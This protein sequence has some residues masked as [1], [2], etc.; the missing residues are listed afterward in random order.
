ML[1]YDLSSGNTVRSSSSYVC[2][3]ESQGCSGLLWVALGCSGLLYYCRLLCVQLFGKIRSA[4]W[5]R[6]GTS[7]TGLTF[8]E[9]G[10]RSDAQ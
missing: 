3:S 9:Q 1:D 4:D 7:G 6:S 8:E 5:I 10:N 2:T